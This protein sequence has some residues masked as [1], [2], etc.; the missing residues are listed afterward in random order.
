VEEVYRKKEEEFGEAMLRYLEKVIMLQSIDHHWKDHLLAIDQLKEGIG[1]RGYGQKDPRIEYQKEAYQMFLEM[2]DRIKKDTVEKLFAIQ[3]AKKEEVKDLQAERKQ[4]FVLSRGE[5]AQQGGGET[6]DGKGVTVRR[7]GKK[8]GRN[9][10][11]P[12]GSGKKY[13]KCCLLKETQA[14]A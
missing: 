2:M 14:R 9:D 6:E 4:T 12:C 11:C 10:P 3:I 8:V 1:L 7:E 13:K 5:T